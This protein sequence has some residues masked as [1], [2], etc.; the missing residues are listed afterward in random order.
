M[1]LVGNRIVEWFDVA[2]LTV[3]RE[4]RRGIYE[5]PDG[6]REPSLE[7]KRDCGLGCSCEAVIIKADPGPKLAE[8]KS[9]CFNDSKKQGISEIVGTAKAIKE[10]PD[11]WIYEVQA[12]LR[13]CRVAA[14][15]SDEKR[16]LYPD[17]P[18]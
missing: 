14:C 4:F 11:E 15:G 2:T 1:G 17:L 6:S 7:L 3:R 5:F 12:K 9:L 8:S 10:G 16:V 13:E 18:F